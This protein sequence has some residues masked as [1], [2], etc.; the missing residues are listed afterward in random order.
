MHTLQYYA[1]HVLF[2]CFPLFETFTLNSIA[3]SLFIRSGSPKSLQ[4]IT[5]KL[6]FMSLGPWIKPTL[7]AIPFL[8]HIPPLQPLCPSAIHQSLLKLPWLRVV[9]IVKL[10]SPPLLCWC[11][12]GGIPWLSRFG[13]MTSVPFEQ[14]GRNRK[15]IQNKRMKKRRTRRASECKAAKYYV[16]V[17]WGGETYGPSQR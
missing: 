12:C 1:F 6:F 10:Q 3:H 16:T 11:P 17:G 5:D 9:W 8:I 7:S 2:P 15:E 14:I 13:A 4:I